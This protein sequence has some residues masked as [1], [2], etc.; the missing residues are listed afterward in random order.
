MLRAEAAFSASVRETPL[1]VALLGAGGTGLEER[2]RVRRTLESEGILALVPEDDLPRHVG[3]S[4]LEPYVLARAGIDLIFVGTDSWGSVSEFM[5]FHRDRK[6]A[7]KLRVLV[8]WKHHPLYGRG[9]GYLADVYLT[10][11]AV[12][13]HVY[14]VDANGRRPFP[15]PRTVILRLS[16]RYRVAKAERANST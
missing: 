2:R 10:H 1:G 12:F 8:P 5:Q 14:A 13:G 11:L 6:I 3:P 4:V 15:T 9:R 7:P 16:R